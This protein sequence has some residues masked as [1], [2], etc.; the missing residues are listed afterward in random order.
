MTIATSARIVV[1]SA[2]DQASADALAHALVTEKLAACVTRL[3]GA[4]STYRW[5]R[6]GAAGV[7]EATE[8]VCFIK[9]QA[10]RVDALLVRLREIHPYE[11][12]EGLTLAVESGLPDYLAWLE[13]STR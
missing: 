9:T 7:E 5:T 12:P 3:P 13:A 10:D 11:V 2:P 8:V 6:D 1:T 4:K